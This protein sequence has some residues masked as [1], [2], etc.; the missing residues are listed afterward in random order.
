[1]KSFTVL[2][3]LGL[4]MAVAGAISWLTSVCWPVVLMSL[5]LGLSVERRQ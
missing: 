1:V 2:M 5:L 4:L 3:A